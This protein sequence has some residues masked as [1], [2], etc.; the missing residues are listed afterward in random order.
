M[1]DFLDRQQGFGEYLH[2]TGISAVIPSGICVRHIGRS[3]SHSCWN[4]GRGLC[5]PFFLRIERNEISSET[6]DD[7]D[8]TLRGRSGLPHN[9][10]VIGIELG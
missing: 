5:V 3:C 7:Y 4:F 10:L 2:G 8:V 6:N 1:G 9:T